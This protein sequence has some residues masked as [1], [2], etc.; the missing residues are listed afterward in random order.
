MILN[1]KSICNSYFHTLYWGCDLTIG[2][3]GVSTNTCTAEIPTSLFGSTTRSQEIFRLMKDDSFLFMYF[4]YGEDLGLSSYKIRCF[5]IRACYSAWVYYSS[6][7]FICSSWFCFSSI[8]R[9]EDSSSLRSNSSSFFANSIYRALF[10]SSRRFFC[11]SIYSFIFYISNS[12]K[13]L[14]LYLS[15]MTWASSL[16]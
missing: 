4:C 12:C 11:C 3:D 6:K 8:A 5:E 2:D 15:A 10:S 7:I 1:A 16:F 13:I 14:S 9:R